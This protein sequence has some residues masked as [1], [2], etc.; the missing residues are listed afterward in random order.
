MDRVKKIFGT[1]EQQP[2]AADAQPKQQGD[3]SEED[4]FENGLF[5]NITSMIVNPT[6]M[7]K[8]IEAQLEEIMRQIEAA[9]ANDEPQAGL[10]IDR[11][12][13]R[14][15][16]IKGD[17]FKRL[18]G[19]SGQVPFISSSPSFRDAPPQK[20]FTD[21]EKVMD[22]IH[23]TVP[24]TPS[25]AGMLAKRNAEVA[26]FLPSGHPNIDIWGPVMPPGA[27]GGG[28]GGRGMFQGVITTTL[29]RSDGV[30]VD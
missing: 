14:D 19:Q 28:P 18:M 26:P 3:V 20:K 4:V 10:P 9:E 12:Q 25:N 11:M 24:E 13:L 22:R 2:T 1:Q 5:G 15:D 30:R 17:D 29:R 23:G 16:E 6:E 21:D 8:Q 27:G 7:Q